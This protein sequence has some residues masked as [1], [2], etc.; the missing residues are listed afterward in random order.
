WIRVKI[1]KIFSR[2]AYAVVAGQRLFP[3]PCCQQRH[4]ILGKLLEFHGEHRT[5]PIEL[6]QD[7]EAV[8]E[9]L[10]AKTRAEEATPLQVHLE[11]LTRLRRGPQPLAAIIPLIL[12]RLGTVVV[13]S[14]NHE[15]AGP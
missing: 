7:L 10:P 5:P 2:L 14:E 12:A 6:R 3:H 13:Q 15:G 8:I 4:Y 9:H 11:Q 1:A